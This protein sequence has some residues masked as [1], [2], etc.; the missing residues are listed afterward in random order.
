MKMIVIGRRGRERRR[1]N[2]REREGGGKSCMHNIVYFCSPRCVA[3]HAGC[4][5][6]RQFHGAVTVQNV[7]TVGRFLEGSEECGPVAWLRLDMCAVVY[8]VM[9]IVGCVG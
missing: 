5:Y 7:R 4:H 2:Q 3:F 1:E 9:Q 6:D 8:C